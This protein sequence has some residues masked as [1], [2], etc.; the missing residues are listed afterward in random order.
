MGETV[1][2]IIKARAYYAPAQIPGN[3]YPSN[4]Q[5]TSTFGV[6][7]VLLTTTSMPAADV[8]AMVKSVFE[9]FQELR[10]LHP[11]LDGLSHTTMINVDAIAPLH[12][13]AARLFRE[14]GWIR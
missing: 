5:D 1:D 6:R 2:K 3:L 13:G 8:Y 11:A 10:K 12:E 9:N 4:P 7:A 14:K